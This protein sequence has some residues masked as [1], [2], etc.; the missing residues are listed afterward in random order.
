MAWIPSS[1]PQ[2]S[3]LVVPTLS[4]VPLAMLAWIAISRVRFSRRIST[5]PSSSLTEAALVIGTSSPR[6]ERTRIR[7]IL[8][9]S[10]RYSG[11]TWTR[12]SWRRPPSSKD[13]TFSPASRVR[14]VRPIAT[15]ETPRSAARPRST[16]SVI[17]GLPV[18]KEVPT[19]TKTG[20]SRIRAV[21]WLA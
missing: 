21:S 12:T 10:S 4:G 17:W 20:S 7:S 5:G 8:A 1:A 6:S 13:P 2:A 14:I 19:S 15:A 11:R 3:N 18:S 9:G 16:S